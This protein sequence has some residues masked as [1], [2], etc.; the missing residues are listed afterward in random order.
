MCQ[1][2]VPFSFVGTV[3][4]VGNAKLLLDYQISHLKVRPTASLLRFIYL[5]LFKNV[6]QHLAPVLQHVL[7]TACHK[8]SH[9]PHALVLCER[10][11][12]SVYVWSWPSQQQ[13]LF[14]CQAVSSRLTGRPQRKPGGCMCWAGSMMWPGLHCLTDQRCCFD[15]SVMQWYICN[16]IVSAADT[17]LDLWQA[18][19]Y[20]QC[21]VYHWILWPPAYYWYWE[22]KSHL[23]HQFVS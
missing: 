10:K 7:R 15:V 4:S 14:G 20:I 8:T 2:S 5:R 1:S 11:I 17:W 6:W 21:G 22:T 18:D 13:V 16:T 23:F 3:E 19:I 9:V 12:A